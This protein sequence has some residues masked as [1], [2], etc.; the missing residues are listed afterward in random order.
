[1]NSGHTFSPSGRNRKSL[2]RHIKP[3]CSILKRMIAA[4][5]VRN[6]WNNGDYVYST[7]SCLRNPP[8]GIRP[9]APQEDY[10]NLFYRL[11]R[12]VSKYFGPAKANDTCVFSANAGRC[13]A[14]FA[15]YHSTVIP[16]LS[17]PIRALINCRYFP[18]TFA[19]PRNHA[20]NECS[21]SNRTAGLRSRNT[22]AARSCGKARHRSQ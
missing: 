21:L 16:K 14:V 6:A 20:P 9:K 13:G 11:L 18:N 1:M 10:L 22:G 3:A 4:D 12:F 15:I 5:E 2:Q 7:R 17:R 8:G 19:F